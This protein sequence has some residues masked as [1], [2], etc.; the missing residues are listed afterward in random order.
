[1]DNGDWAN[2]SHEA[3]RYNPAGETPLAICPICKAPVLEEHGPVEVELD[4]GKAGF[5]HGAFDCMDEPRCEE[6]RAGGTYNGE[7]SQR[8]V[9]PAPHTGACYWGPVA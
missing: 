1:M 6:I 7:A 5:I 4:S 9:L 3:L 8:C 2:D